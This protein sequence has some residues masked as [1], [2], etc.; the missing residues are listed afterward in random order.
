MPPEVLAAPLGIASVSLTA[1]MRGVMAMADTDP[2]QATRLATAY[3]RAAEQRGATA[4]IW[5]WGYVASR[6]ARRAP[7]RVLLGGDGRLDIERAI[8]LAAHWIDQDRWPLGASMLT[9]LAAVCPPASPFYGRLAHNAMG[10]TAEALQWVER[11]RAWGAERQDGWWQVA[12]SSLT[13]AVLSD[14]PGF[15]ARFVAAL[16]VLDAWRPR[17]APEP[18][19]LSWA[20][21]ARATRALRAGRVGEARQLA[22]GL[23]TLLESE[24]DAQPDLARIADV[25]ARVVSLDQGPAAGLAALEPM[26]AVAEHRGDPGY[27]LLPAQMTAMELAVKTRCPGID[28]TLAWFVGYL[29]G[30]GADRQVARLQERPGP[31]PALR[32]GLTW[33]PVSPPLQ[34]IGEKEEWL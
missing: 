17:G 18:L 6:L 5:G 23:L 24:P 14:V 22:R 25:R 3:Q 34:M 20:A 19:V 2:A 12:A 32:N 21:T 11:S 26:L 27:A 29:G 28:A 10:R 7:A 30:A 9:S 15:G 31:T 4:D 16:A 33:H 1:R 8:E 13:A